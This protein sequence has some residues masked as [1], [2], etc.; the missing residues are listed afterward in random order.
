[1]R[2]GEALLSL[3]NL[4][5]FVALAMPL[6]RPTLWMRRSP[7]I[8][9][10]IALAQMLAEGPR[11]QMFPA[12]ALTGLFVLVWLL[13]HIAHTGGLNKQKRT[14]R[15]AVGLG[16]LVLGAAL[17]L[18]MMIP[19]FRFPHPSGR[20]GI[21]TLTYHWVDPD[22]LEI[23]SADPRARRE[24]M[25][26][27]WYPARDDRSSR[28]ALYLADADAVTTAFARIHKKPEFMFGHFTYVTTNA[29]SSALV[30]ADE[31]SYPVLLFLEGAT[32]F[33]QMNTFQVE[34]LVSHGYVVAAI[35]QPGAA[36][37]VVFPDGRKA[38]GLALA[39]L[40]AL[41][42]PSYMPAMSAPLLNGRALQGN[43][44]IP[45]LAQ[46]ASFTL[47]QLG[48]LNRAD[49][50][51]ILTGRLDLHHA[52]AF[53][54]SLGG[55][56]VGEACLLEPRLR[57]CLV[58]DAAMPAEVVKAG[59][60]QP[61]MWIT[62]DADNMRLERQRAGGWPEAEIEAHQ[63][64]MRAVYQSLPGSGYFVQVPGMFHSNF[65]DVPN[66]FPLASRVGLTGPI[67]GERGHKIVNA[68][69]LAFFDRHLK[70]R[71]AT[72]LDGPAGQYPEVLF[73][74]RRP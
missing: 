47:E 54:F 17:V 57:A 71:P 66:W 34:E 7:P 58:M 70:G 25:V 19:V 35:D 22:R 5:A 61:S 16:V 33:R 55:I 1:M 49:P 43:S 62:R 18:P 37:A 42:G 32:G 64:S 39:Q 40:H 36:A 69:S 44:I 23:F 60:E 73:E 8:A 24:L 59:L 50:N 26:Q 30:A 51:G 14:H 13:Q 10:L 28:R 9:L 53:G 31:L 46:D 48:A 65:M 63:A 41:I 29:I 4:L 2:P 52:G 72:L 20:Y 3:A 27:I 67:D 21:G 68:Y 38:A 6:P 45:Y 11:W 15:I 74:S 56:V 12:Y